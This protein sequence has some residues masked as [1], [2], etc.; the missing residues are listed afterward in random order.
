[1]CKYLSQ[2]SL[3]IALTSSLSAMQP[4]TL[5]QESVDL[6]KRR[7]V[8]IQNTTSLSL[9][10]RVEA[11]DDASNTVVG[12]V[13]LARRTLGEY[14]ENMQEQETVKQ[15]EFQLKELENEYDDQLTLPKRRA[16]IEAVQELIRDLVLPQCK[17]RS[18]VERTEQIHTLHQK[19]ILLYGGCL[20]K[21]EVVLCP[22][23]LCPE[24]LIDKLYDLRVTTL[25]A[26]LD[27]YCNKLETI[28]ADNAWAYYWRLLRLYG[29]EVLGEY[30]Q[31]RPEQYKR[32]FTLVVTMQSAYLSDE[33]RKQAALEM[34]KLDLA[35]E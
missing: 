35:S 22:Q 28:T 18:E 14:V 27:E 17:A 3:V 12:L 10:E 15:W 16:E 32:R 7:K 4:V 9:E 23:W 24:W 33:D 34:W 2:I 26:E 1:M 29:K 25:E 6:P 21:D 5:V 30:S 31:E 20:T 8:L 11:M 13:G 19:A